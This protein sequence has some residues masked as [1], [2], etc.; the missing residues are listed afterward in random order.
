MRETKEDIGKE[1]DG[2]MMHEPFAIMSKNNSLSRASVGPLDHMGQCMDPFFRRGRA[3]Q[4]AAKSWFRVTS[5]LKG[6]NL[7]V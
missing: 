6:N 4:D 5:T 3:K 2:D 1:A 7:A